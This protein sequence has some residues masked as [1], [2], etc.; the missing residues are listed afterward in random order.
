MTSAARATSVAALALLTTFAV[1]SC[2]ESSDTAAESK[3]SS[4]LG[5][6]LCI[7]N[8]STIPA[9]VVFTRKDTGNGGTISRGGTTCG[10]GTFGTDNDVEGGITWGSPGWKTQFSANNPWFGKPTAVVSE[11]DPA[12][13]KKCLA[14]DFS[15]NESRSGDNGLVRMTLTRQADGQ[16]KEFTLRI[17]PSDTPDASGQRRDLSGTQQCPSGTREHI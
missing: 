16:W 8:N 11:R 5:T 7:T 6:R 13:Q 9:T 10:E 1:S 3:E 17:D 2:S 15:V 12:D 4:N 14:G